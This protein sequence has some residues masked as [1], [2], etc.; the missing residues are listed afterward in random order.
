MLTTFQ[1]ALCEHRAKKSDVI[2]YHYVGRLGDSGEVFGRR[3]VQRQLNHYHRLLDYSFFG[4]CVSSHLLI[5]TSAE[6][7]DVAIKVEAPLHITPTGI[8]ILMLKVI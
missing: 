4:L 3:Y 7:N 2:H 8:L 5:F 1:P 6:K